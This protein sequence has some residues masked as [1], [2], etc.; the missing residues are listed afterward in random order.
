MKMNLMTFFEFVS[1]YDP[2]DSQFEKVIMLGENIE[3]IQPPFLTLDYQV[4]KVSVRVSVISLGFH[5]VSSLS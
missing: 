4:L 3:F 5:I 2:T 1:T